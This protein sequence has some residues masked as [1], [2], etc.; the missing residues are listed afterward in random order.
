LTFSGDY[1]PLEFRARLD[2]HLS[3]VD[4]CGTSALVVKQKTYFGTAF[5]RHVMKCQSRFC[6]VCSRSIRAKWRDRLKYFSDNKRLVFCTLTFDDDSPDKWEDPKYFTRVFNRWLSRLRRRYPSVK[7]VRFVE[8]TKSGRPHF[9]I[10][11]DRFIP[12]K[13]ISQ[14]FDECGGGRIVDIRAVDPCHAIGY[15]TKYITKTYSGSE[16]L[17]VWL[18]CTNTRSVSASRGI[19]YL[20]SKSGLVSL[21]KVGSEFSID[22]YFSRL[23]DFVPN[24]SKAIL[25]TWSK[26][27]PVLFFVREEDLPAFM[28]DYSSGVLNYRSLLSERHLDDFREKP[29]VPLYYS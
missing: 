27:P 4:S 12:Q 16:E 10:L 3:R 11:F 28:Q 20:V 8:L 21:C 26:S 24:G 6:P 19:Y 13:W 15:V 18:Y 29:D 23:E 2:Q 9:H 22:Y 25:S 1:I 17:T 5:V 7:Y 14:S